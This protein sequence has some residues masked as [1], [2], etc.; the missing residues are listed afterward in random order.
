MKAVITSRADELESKLKDV[1]KYSEYLKSR[2][3]WY[4]TEA[5]YKIRRLK[6]DLDT[7]KQISIISNLIN[8][9]LLLLL[10]LHV[11]GVF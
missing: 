10:A 7:F 8:L 9:I 1:I 2:I 6:A 3:D 5:N 4:H 11:W